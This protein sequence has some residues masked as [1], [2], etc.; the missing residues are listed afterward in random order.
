MSYNWMN[1]TEEEIE[2][3]L[4]SLVAK[5]LLLVVGHNDEGE[6]LY[7][8]SN[9]GRRAA[10]LIPGDPINDEEF[11]LLDASSPPGPVT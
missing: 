9:K 3:A 11:I 4:D 8:I 7:D 5:G 6:A 1:S 2:A 10:E